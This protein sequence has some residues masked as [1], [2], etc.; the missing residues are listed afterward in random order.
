MSPIALP[1][2]GEYAE[3]YG[4]YVSRLAGDDLI[5]ILERQGAAT[6]RLLAATTELL[7]AL[8]YAPGKWSVREVVGH[9][10]DCERVFAYRA[11][12]IGRGDPTPLPAFDEN[13]WAPEGRFERRTLADLAAELAS[14]RAATLSLFRS[15]DETA[16]A[17]RG[18]GG[19]NP[20]TPRG[21]AAII[22]GHEMHHLELLR[23]RY[24][25]TE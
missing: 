7:A 9:V 4:R 11:L 19:G 12:S 25:L 24:G 20:V 1:G 6:A 2:A 16:F 3:Y 13:L 10:S 8:R 15:F 22:A 18:T 5:A 14:V 17:R 21:L 23:E